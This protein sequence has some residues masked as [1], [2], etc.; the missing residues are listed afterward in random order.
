[1]QPV[2]FRYINITW[3]YLI[4]NLLSL[5]RVL[6]SNRHQLSKSQ[7]IK[8]AL[9]IIENA[10]ESQ[11]E[12]SDAT[13]RL[14][15]ANLN[16]GSVHIETITNEEFRIFDDYFSVG[17]TAEK[18]LETYIQ[19][20]IHCAIAFR[21]ELKNHATRLSSAEREALVQGIHDALHIGIDYLCIPDGHGEVA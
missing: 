21:D 10:K 9:E 20:S 1:M 8:R 12:I 11:E 19:N 18:P 16:Y 17:R 6:I 2:V 7:N 14:A 5:P 3:V 4:M 13:Y 15:L